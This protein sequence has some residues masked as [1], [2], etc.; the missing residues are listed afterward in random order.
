MREPKNHGALHSGLGVLDRGLLGAFLLGGYGIAVV[1]IAFGLAALASV[2]GWLPLPGLGAS[3]WSEAPWVPWTNAGSSLVLGALAWRVTRRDVA[4][5]P[6][7][8]ARTRPVL[9]FAAEWLALAVSL[10]AMIQGFQRVLGREGAGGIPLGLGLLFLGW[11]AL[12]GWRRYAR[13]WPLGPLDSAADPAR[14][15]PTEPR[16]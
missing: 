2:L 15:N 4:A 14:A 12:L 13:L 1:L 10:A 8:R 7:K 5:I 16:S 11:L 6:R 3:D 9:F